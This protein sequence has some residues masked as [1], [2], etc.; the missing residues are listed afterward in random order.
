MENQHRIRSAALLCM[1]GALL[2]IVALLIQYRYGL[3]A[4]DGG[5]LY[6]I[7]QSMFALAMIGHMLGV[8]GLVWAQPV[9]GR[10]GMITLGLFLAGWCALFVALTFSLLTGSAALDLLLPI[11]GIL[12]NLCGLL[13]GIA[14]VVARRWGGW[15][16]YAVLIYGLYFALVLLAPNL[17]AGQEPTLITEAGWELTW[18]LIGAALYTSQRAS[19]GRQKQAISAQE[20]IVWR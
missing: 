6:V 15:Q 16:R 9:N 4:P 5:A 11:G 2:W 8:L 19:N 3:F 12:G 20:G 17:I 18:L 10:F 1:A 14:I 13:A 7:N